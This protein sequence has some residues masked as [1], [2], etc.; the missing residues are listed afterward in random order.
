[1]TAASVQLSQLCWQWLR[2]RTIRCNVLY[3]PKN[4]L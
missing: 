2:Y 1:M 3:V 4:W